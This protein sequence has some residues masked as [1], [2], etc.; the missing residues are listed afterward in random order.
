MKLVSIIIP[1]FKKKKY[2]LTTIRSALN[3]T[4]SKFEIIL[5]YDDEDKRDLDY[6]N[7]LKRLDNRI[8]IIINKKNIGAGF[9][10]NKGIKFSKGDYIAFLDADDIWYPS[11]LNKQIN[12]MIKN[13]YNITH[14][15][16]EIFNEVKSQ[17]PKVRKA[18]PIVSFNELLN[19]CDIGLSTVVVKK[20][21]L[22]NNFKFP[23]LK[24]KEDYVLWLKFLKKGIKIFAINKTLVK[25]RSTKGSLSSSTL[26]KI[27]DGFVVYNKFMKFNY[28][29]SLYYLLIL[30]INYLKKS[31]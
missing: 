6:I 17:K 9:S 23:N 25:W 4:Y 31:Y 8:K 12:F 1:Y 22:K 2:I 24:T 13:K 3:Q 18:S 15:S 5:I 11:K 20:N 14:T 29:K 27:T 21:L 7:K 10:R 19:S 26:Q 16:Y 28:L 30:S